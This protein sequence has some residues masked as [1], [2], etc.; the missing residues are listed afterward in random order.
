[1]RKKGGKLIALFVDLKAAF[2]SV[3]K[4]VL[5]NEMR[6]RRIREGRIKSVG[7]IMWKTKST[8]RLRAGGEI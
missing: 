7:E 3:D 2:D 6:R 8:S 1:M 5:L 4:V